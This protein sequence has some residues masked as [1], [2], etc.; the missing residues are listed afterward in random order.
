MFRCFKLSYYY[1]PETSESELYV[2][3]VYIIAGLYR[4]REGHGQHLP[5]NLRHH[6]LFCLLGS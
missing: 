4:C 2:F 6:S 3:T 1:Y 5:V